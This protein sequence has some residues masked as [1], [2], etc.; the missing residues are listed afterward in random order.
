MAGQ[1]RSEPSTADTD[2][3]GDGGARDPAPSSPSPIL[4]VRTLPIEIPLEPLAIVRHGSP[5][6]FDA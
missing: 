6:T 2:Q 4:A 5:P 1:P 3:D